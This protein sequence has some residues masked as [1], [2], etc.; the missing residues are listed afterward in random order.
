M[1]IVF[2]LSA[3]RDLQEAY[4][5]WLKSTVKGES[6]FSWGGAESPLGTLVYDVGPIGGQMVDIC[7]ECLRED[8]RENR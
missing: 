5:W 4:H 7:V 8:F 6:S 3:E 1:E 2:F